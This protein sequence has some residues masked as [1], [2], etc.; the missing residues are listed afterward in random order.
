MIDYSRLNNKFLKYYF[1]SYGFKKLFEAWA[2]SGSTR[3]YLGITGQLDLP[4]LMSPIDVQIAIAE[5]LGAL[6]EKIES[7]RQMNHTLEKMAQGVSSRG[8]WTSIP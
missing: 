2:N 8:L 1:N 6:D 4:I 5:V 7:N 3:S